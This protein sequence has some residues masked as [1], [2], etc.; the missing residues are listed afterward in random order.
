MTGITGIVDSV[1][2]GGVE[3]PRQVGIST[4]RYRMVRV[5]VFAGGFCTGPWYRTVTPVPTHTK[6]GP[7]FPA[8]LA[9]KVSIQW[10]GHHPWANRGRLPMGTG[11][12]PQPMRGPCAHWT[13]GK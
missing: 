1:G 2:W 12:R 3:G 4:I 5:L 8:I 11:R 7:H 6:P 13:G 9:A 10:Q